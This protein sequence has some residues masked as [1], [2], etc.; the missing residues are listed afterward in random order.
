MIALGRRDG[1]AEAPFFTTTVG[2]PVN[3]RTLQK[4]F[5]I[6]CDRA[7]IRR[8]D[9]GEQPR[10]HDMRHTFAVHRLTSWY[11]QGADVQRLLQHLS[12]YLGHVHLRHTQVYLSMTPELLREASQRFARYA[13]RRD[14][15][16]NTDLL[17]PLGPPVLVG[18][19]RCR[20]EPRP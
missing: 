20:A 8:T 15:M 3:T 2:R 16:T 10:I 14:A 13:G 18:V 9:T 1:P 7:G 12:V 5:R 11:Q 4:T 19:P 6:A 17:L